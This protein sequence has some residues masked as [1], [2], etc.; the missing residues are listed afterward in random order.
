MLRDSW[1]KCG[2]CFEVLGD[3]VRWVHTCNEDDE[4]W[5]GL[6]LVTVVGVV[7]E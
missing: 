3:T 7:R 2:R 5:E 1:A 4:V 6:A